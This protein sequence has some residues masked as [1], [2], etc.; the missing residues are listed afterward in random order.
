MQGLYELQVAI[1]HECLRQLS[2]IQLDDSNQHSDRASLVELALR[3]SKP[4]HQFGYADTAVMCSVQLRS[5][6][7]VLA[8]LHHKGLCSLD[9]ELWNQLSDNVVELFRKVTFEPESSRNK[10]LNNR[11]RHAPNVYLILLTAQYIS[12][13]QRGDSF[14]ASIVTP[15][16]DVMFA[17][18]SLA[19]GQYGNIQQI[20]RGVDQILSIWRRPPTKY[21]VLV[22][23][24]YARQAASAF[25]FTRG[26]NDPG[27]MRRDITN[28]VSRLL[29]H[30][31]S[32]F[33]SEFETSPRTLA[34]YW[35][36]HLA[37]FHRG[38]PKLDP[39]YY[40]YGLLDCVAQ[41]MSFTEAGMLPQRLAERLEE[42]L[43]TSEAAEIR[44]KTIEIFLSCTSTRAIQYQSLQERIQALPIADFRVTT[45][46]IDLV[47]DHLIDDESNAL[48]EEEVEPGAGVI[49][50]T[51]PL[52]DVDTLWRENH[53]PRSRIKEQ[54]RLLFVLPSRRLFRRTSYHSAGF[55]P[56][57]RRIY[58]H[59]DEHVCVYEKFETPAN[60]LST[61]PSLTFNKSFKSVRHV[62]I[63][64]RFLVI[65]R[66]KEML[67]F[68]TASEP[69]LQPLVNDISSP[70]GLAIYEKGVHLIIVLG[71]SHACPS[72]GIKGQVKIYKYL[73]GR[74]LE[75]SHI[76]RVIPLPDGDYPKRL[77]IEAD[78]TL[79]CCVTRRQNKLFAW[80]IDDELATPD[81]PF[82][83]LKNNY[84]PVRQ[85]RI[86]RM[87]SVMVESVLIPTAQET[88][89]TGITST[90]LYRSPSNRSYLLC[91]TSPSAERWH[92]HGEWSFSVP[93][94]NTDTLVRT[95]PPKVVHNFEQFR[96]HRALVASAVSNT[97][98]IL[99]VLG[100]TG[101]IS[102][103]QLDAHE[104]GGIHSQEKEALKVSQ[105]LAEQERPSASCLRFDPEGE[106]L[107]A[108][109]NKGMVVIVEFEKT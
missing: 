1:D 15:A 22:I 9:P 56:D 10:S 66:A 29:D 82:A 32:I 79:V 57:C 27:D 46:E 86:V 80:K 100:E 18:F 67:I 69:E 47:R 60:G 89:E 71:Q 13:W 4:L 21:R 65:A 25:R 43:F 39:S 33:A 5:L 8:L 77:Y 62:A 37:A 106:R 44:W 97:H 40:F 92:N 70:S 14:R 54:P 31:E 78:A 24:E 76:T 6:I 61:S 104:D 84:T 49:P 95:P 55:S 58:F 108:V 17:G 93:V 73:I 101:E 52:E 64:A 36:K 53:F 105:Q 75:A 26:V 45:P 23:Q 35:H 3:L 48:A 87:S 51:P 102:I 81:E 91:S 11:I 41:I 50:A 72:T 85:G 94:S 107:F 68:K 63:S 16:F 83:Y 98:N 99:A 109:D 90:S 30:I 88:R 38:P 103:L 28:F 42:L 20:L 96:K 59:D 74:G 19:G 34:D 7:A 12:F 2:G